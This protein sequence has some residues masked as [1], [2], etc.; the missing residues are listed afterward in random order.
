MEKL[1]I[2]SKSDTV[3]DN[4]SLLKVI[5]FIFVPTSILT[6][7]YI[8]IGHF[9]QDVIP[10]LLL[11]FLLAMIFLFPVQLI[12]VLRASKIEF[13]KYSFK[14]SFSNYQKLSW[15]K[16]LIYGA[17]LWGFAGIMSVTLAP[18]EYSLFA[19]ISDRLFNILPEYF[20]WNNL[21]YLRQYP[22]PMLLLTFAI[23]AIFNIFIGPITEELFFRGYLTAKI[24][25]YGKLAPLIITI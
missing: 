6:L 13:G 10:S 14:S 7:S 15:W 20:N 12:I 17:L 22:R 19:P 11:F 16:V 9:V 8:V 1:T 23:L 3:N 25:R 4:L 24:S 18:L 2:N 21:E 5:M